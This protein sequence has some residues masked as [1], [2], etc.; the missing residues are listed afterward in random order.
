MSSNHVPVSILNRPTLE[1][2]HN[3][4]PGMPFRRLDVLLCAFHLNPRPT[5]LC[6]LPFAK[7]EVTDV[8]LTFKQLYVGETTERE[9]LGT[10]LFLHEQKH[11]RPRY[12][13][14]FIPFGPSPPVAQT[15]IQDVGVC[16]PHLTLGRLPL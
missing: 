13:R 15:C 12:L 7:K 1:N 9:H 16:F 4:I 10:R 3:L 8:P 2:H 11:F 14:T 6:C 5:I